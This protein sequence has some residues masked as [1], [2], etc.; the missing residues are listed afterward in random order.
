MTKASNRTTAPANQIGVLGTQRAAAAAPPGPSCG[1]FDIRIAR[2]GTWYYRGSPIGRPAL[3]KLFA[4]VL[5]RDE[6]GDHWLVTPAERGRIRVEDAPFT[7]VE[8]SVEGSGREQALTFRTNLDEL[9][10]ASSA[11]PI[12][13][14]PKGPNDEPRPYLLVRERL[15][16]LIARPVYYQLVELGVEGPSSEE[17]LF[18]VWSRGAFFALGTLEEGR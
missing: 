5:R 12:R 9:V 4:S 15:E 17:A 13:L 8:L 16:A 3:V 1:D 11:H 2:D 14:S 10:T 18:G 6:A 7:A